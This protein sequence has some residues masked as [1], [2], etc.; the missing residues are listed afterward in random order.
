MIK[1]YL[2]FINERKIN[3]KQLNLFGD[4]TF[5][6]K[7][8]VEELLINIIDADIYIETIFTLTTKTSI[9]NNNLDDRIYLLIGDVVNRT[10]RIHIK[11][12]F[13]SDMT[14]TIKSF[15]EYLEDDYEIYLYIDNEKVDINDIEYKDNEIIRSDNNYNYNEEIFIYLVYTKEEKVMTQ[16]DIIEYYNL[17]GYVED[18]DKI[19]F[20]I[21]MDDIRDLTLEKNSNYE[22][23]I[24]DEV[25]FD[26]NDNSH[27]L[28]Y[29]DLLMHHL[30]DENI[31]NLSKNMIDEY[32]MHGDDYLSEMDIEIH[33]IGNSEYKDINNE[34]SNDI[35]SM[36][37]DWESQ[38]LFYKNVEE[39]IDNFNQKLAET[40]SFTT[41]KKAIKENGDKITHYRI[42]FDNYFLDGPMDD[43]SNYRG[44]FGSDNEYN[45]YEDREL[46]D[47]FYEFCGS[48]FYKFE[49]NPRFTDYG[50]VDFNSFN[51][52]VEMMIKQDNAYKA[53]NKK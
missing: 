19:F 24:S 49:L 47:L 23:Y 3:E 37:Q 38:D 2:N 14:D 30:N 31:L 6:T 1:K 26:Y 48:S 21:T 20:D 17:K 27:Y 32:N 10:C 8:E 25:D 50:S 16:K 46:S 44:D 42:L 12:S 39:A 36:Y 7:D 15:V 4:F 22:K 40:F 41:Y 35:I 5:I 18:K 53:K 28:T 9:K 51:K 11:N 34:L 52:E 43:N 45:D 13:E 33:E 29:N